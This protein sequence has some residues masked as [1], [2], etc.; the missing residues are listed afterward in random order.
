M[1]YINFLEKNQPYGYYKLETYLK[2]ILI[3]KL[4]ELTYFKKNI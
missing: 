4:N 1:E 3:E 2:N